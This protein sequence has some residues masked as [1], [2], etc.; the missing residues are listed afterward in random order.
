M[1][2]IKTKKLQFEYSLLISFLLFFVIL[3]KSATTSYE[4]LYPVACSPAAGGVCRWCVFLWVSSRIGPAVAVA[5]PITPPPASAVANETGLH[6]L[7][8]SAAS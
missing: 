6:S 4:T 7:L 8:V 5:K 2:T 3:L 1:K